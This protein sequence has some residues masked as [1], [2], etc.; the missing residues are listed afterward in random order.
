[1]KIVFLDACTVS[2]ENDV[3]LSG[4]MAL[5]NWTSH[6]ITAPSDTA[7]RI[8]EADV[9]ISN[10]VIL[11][12]ASIA[13]APKLRLIAVAATGTNNVDFEAAKA[14]GIQVCN[15][16]GYSTHSVAQHVL[17]LVLNLATNIHRTVAK[18]EA[19]PQSPI[20][21]RLD[22][23]I[24]QLADLTLGLVGV[25]NIGSRVGE[26]AEA[27]G[28]KVQC[29]A[30]PQSKATAHPE[31]P[32]VAANAFFASSDVVSLHCPLTE[33]TR[34]LINAET[35]GKMKPGAFLINTGRGE[36]IDETVLLESLLSGHLGGAG[37]DVLSKEPPRDDHPLITAD[38]PNLLIT[39]HSAWSSRTSRQTL[40]HGVE[41]N[42]RAF[43]ETG[44]AT[45][46]VG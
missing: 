31:W 15:V 23:P 25:G 9:V 6:E 5:G 40:I 8:A 45:N 10:K 36:L 42:I 14:R 44:E 27:F 1:M 26:I 4:L 18:P 35:L 3:D 2:R 43:Q 29:Y 38:L 32:R 37:L 33:G 13:A 7:D 22:Y 39:P 20:F 30:R 28:M 19:W 17:A 11:D 12:A 41:A 21:T 24:Q 16:S 34:A 46:R